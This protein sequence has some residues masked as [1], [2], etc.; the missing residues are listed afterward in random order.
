MRHLQTS[1]PRTV[2]AG[3]ERS[4]FKP[5]VGKELPPVDA[6]ARTKTRSRGLT[7]NCADTLSVGFVGFV[8]FVRFVVPAREPPN[9]T[10]LTNLTNPTNFTNFT[11]FT[12]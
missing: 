6:R 12:N 3:M 9:L 8:E 5:Q 11:N 7:E 1:P 2:M 10:N 4:G